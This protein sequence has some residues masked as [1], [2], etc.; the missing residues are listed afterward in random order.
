M[1]RV[2]D[3]DGSWDVDT[4]AVQVQPAGDPPN[5]DPTADL[6]DRDAFVLRWTATDVDGHPLRRCVGRHRR[7]GQRLGLQLTLGRRDHLILAG[8]LHLQP[9]LLQQPG[10]RPLGLRLAVHQVELRVGLAELVGPVDQLLLAGFEYPDVRDRSEPLFTGNVDLD[11]LATLEEKVV[12]EFDKLSALTVEFLQG[13][14]QTFFQG[15][16]YAGPL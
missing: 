2:E 3:S 10:Q 15:I 13:E 14:E 7:G 5:A 6:A 16:R 12:E 8:D 9:V 11:E 4:V 1:L